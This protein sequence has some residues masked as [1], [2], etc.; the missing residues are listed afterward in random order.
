[1]PVYQTTTTDW[2]QIVRA[3]YDEMPGLRLTREQVQ[4]LWSL[5][6]PTCDMLLEALVRSRF[7]CRTGNNAYVRAD[8][9]RC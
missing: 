4:R 8:S 5:D 7:L 1:M 9:S 6:S 3:E 2:I